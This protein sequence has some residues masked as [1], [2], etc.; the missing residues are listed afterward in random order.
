MREGN[1]RGSWEYPATDP[2]AQL[3]SGTASYYHGDALGSITS[4]SSPTGTLANAYTYDSFGN[5]TASTGTITN[6][7]QFT[8]RDYD[9]ETGLHYYRARYYDGKTGRFISEDPTGFNSKQTDF[10]TYAGNSRVLHID[11]SGLALCVL[12]YLGNGKVVL[13]FVTD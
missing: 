2:L 9:S 11:P 8:T 3:R 6:P 13:E 5:V 4:L 10:Y 1:R 12:T 7:F